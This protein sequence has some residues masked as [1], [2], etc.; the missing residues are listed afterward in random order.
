MDN[1]VESLEDT[2][3][4]D[5]NM[6]TVCLVPGDLRDAIKGSADLRIWMDDNLSSKFRG[7]SEEIIDALLEFSGTDLTNLAADESLHARMDTI[8]NTHKTDKSDPSRSALNKISAR[9]INGMVASEGVVEIPQ[10]TLDAFLGM[11]REKHREAV[12]GCRTDLPAD[13]RG[14]CKDCEYYYA[15]T[16]DIVRIQEEE[17]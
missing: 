7:K 13:P 11:V 1:D 14:D 2:F 8:G 12:E 15:C 10:S 17:E 6:R 16:A 9:L 3:N 4:V 5:R